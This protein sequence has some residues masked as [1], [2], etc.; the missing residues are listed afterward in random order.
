MFSAP[1]PWR[2]PGEPLAEDMLGKGG[3]ILLHLQRIIADWPRENTAIL[4]HE[5]RHLR[6]IL[7]VAG[8]PEV[9][10]A[11][12]PF[13]W[14]LHERSI[15]ALRASR[16]LDNVVGRHRGTSLRSSLLN[17]DL[18][19][20][21][22]G[23]QNGKKYRILQEVHEECLLLL[24]A[25][26][27]Q[28]DEIDDDE[29]SSQRTFRREEEAFLGSLHSYDN[30]RRDKWWPDLKKIN[31]HS[32]V[33]V[34]LAP[35][36]GSMPE[37]GFKPEGEEGHDEFMKWG[38]RKKDL[39]E[40]K[41]G[42]QFTMKEG[43]EAQEVTFQHHHVQRWIKEV[44]EFKEFKGTGQRF[45]RGA[46][47]M[48]ELITSEVRHRIAEEIGIGSIT[49][50]GGGRVKFLCPR[51]IYETRELRRLMEDATW[52]FLVLNNKRE[53][54]WARNNVRF[55]STI[56]N[57]ANACFKA[58]HDVD[59]FQSKKKLELK[60]LLLKR[61][62]PVS[63][64]KAVLVE[65]LGDSYNREDL[66]EWF[67]QVQSELPAFSVV[68]GD[69]EIAPLNGKRGLA[70]RLKSIDPAQIIKGEKS[71]NPQS[72]C[73]FC[74]EQKNPFPTEAK[75][76]EFTVSKLK[77]LLRERGLPVFG[78]K[79][80]LVDRLKLKRESIDSHMGIDGSLEKVKSQIC[81][82][83][84]LLYFLGH[85]Q[86]LKDST[87]RPATEPLFE[88]FIIPELEVLLRERGLPVSG[89]KAELVAR[90][91]DPSGNRPTTAIARIDANSLGIL[92]GER[93]EEEIGDEQTLHDRRRRRCFRFNVHWWQS[94]QSSV[95]RYGIGDRVAAWVTAGDDVVL[96]EY[97]FEGDAEE[98]WG[99]K[100][101]K[102]IELLAE[103]IVF[104]EELEN[105]V[106]L[107]FGA[108]V[109]IKRGTR[110]RISKQLPRSLALEKTAKY[111]WRK[112]MSENKPR[113]M[114]LLIDGMDAVKPVGSAKEVWG[115]H[116]WETC[117]IGTTD[118]TMVVEWKDAGDH[119]SSEQDETKPK[120]F[121]KPNF[122]GW[123]QIL[124][125]RIL[126]DPPFSLIKD[127]K[128]FECLKR[129]YVEKWAN[130]N[131]TLVVLVPKPETVSQEE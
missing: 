124:V 82:F 37:G 117:R 104:N 75:L 66:I 51:H 78:L 105:G 99:N 115:S 110:D 111:I 25:R 20:R 55:D 34:D 40:W 23:K 96:A 24:F 119:P 22:E 3:K 73:W 65:R 113:M 26:I 101:R 63:G 50:D 71:Q 4:S 18:N 112:R 97:G 19:W 39:V 57:W 31:D 118:S 126:A 87:L 56:R 88:E 64:S 30:T 107:S 11:T 109:A 21:L 121:V 13:D 129:H 108:G 114:T 27:R 68:E 17:R 12:R 90:L 38:E 29:E 72:K 9:D 100:L 36:P 84:R 77:E 116:T 79:D 41:K 43:A 106:V 52:Q 58:G 2:G 48:L 74:D 120:D 15:E 98:G 32:K 53:G 95:E 8:Y 123:D 67:K 5:E 125:E 7:T 102:T 103:K 44:S 54:S 81:P 28:L 35:N 80:E 128:R 49:V 16:M 69:T 85:D 70:S 83:H 131:R 45:L 60:E 76:K 86:R 10:V 92:F 89:L 14:P 94:I 122:D 93:H 47:I 61:E 62:L 127:D 42:R 33:L 59:D 6:F 1:N 91:G 130:G 46:S